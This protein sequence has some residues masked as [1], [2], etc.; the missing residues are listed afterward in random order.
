MFCRRPEDDL[1]DKK[2]YE[3]KAKNTYKKLKIL[4][5]L[6]KEEAAN[7]PESDGTSAKQ[8][9]KGKQRKT[10]DSDPSLA[11]LTDDRL[12]AYGLEPKKFNYTK[13]RFIQQ[14]AQSDAKSAV[15]GRKKTSKNGKARPVF[16]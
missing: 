6:K 5:S 11:G 15:A 13:H 10:K 12:K 14:N 4:P 1:K 3:Q 7:K 8:K 16:A 2:R 9:T